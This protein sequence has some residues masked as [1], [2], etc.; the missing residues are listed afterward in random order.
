MADRFLR[1]RRGAMASGRAR[2]PCQNW[3]SAC[4]LGPGLPNG[5]ALGGTPPPAEM[6]RRCRGGHTTN[7]L[8]TASASTHAGP[9]RCKPLRAQPWEP[10]HPQHA[11]AMPRAAG[12]WLSPAKLG[13]TSAALLAT[14]CEA[15]WA[16][17][18]RK[19]SGRTR[20]E[21]CFGAGRT[22]M[23]AGLGMLAREYADR[24][25]QRVRGH[26]AQSAGSPEGVPQRWTQ[27]PSEQV[28]L[29]MT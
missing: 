21:P 27:S 4:S 6:L 17:M 25:N 22:L 3:P 11:D 7:S 28:A 9:R 16:Q 12:G 23:Y 26:R 5:L 13:Y 18:A 15:Y 29:G 8:G 1:S 10:R 14:D 2:M 19:Q 24:L 20:G